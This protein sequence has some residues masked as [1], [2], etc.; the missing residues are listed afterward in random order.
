[1]LLCKLDSELFAYKREMCAS[2]H[3]QST[4]QLQ[5]TVDEAAGYNIVRGNRSELGAH[6]QY[7]QA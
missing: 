2:A 7:G 5:H 1:M 4:S 3:R 6:L